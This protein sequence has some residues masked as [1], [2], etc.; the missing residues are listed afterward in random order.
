[1]QLQ[2]TDKVWIQDAFASFTATS[3]VLA[4][5]WQRLSP[6]VPSACIAS[7]KR[8]LEYK[9]LPRLTDKAEY[10]EGGFLVAESN[11]Y[12]VLHGR[13]AGSAPALTP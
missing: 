8:S 6:S 10:Q 11:R 13:N 3:E 12:T 9:R 5:C 7:T 2:V 1:M 4:A